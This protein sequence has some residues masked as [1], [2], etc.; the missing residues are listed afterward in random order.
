MESLSHMPK[1]RVTF[2]QQ[3][4]KV[5]KHLNVSSIVSLYKKLAPECRQVIAYCAFHLYG[6]LGKDCCKDNFI[7]EPIITSEGSCFQTSEKFKQT[8]T[9][10]GSSNS[11]DIYTFGKM[12]W[13]R[14]A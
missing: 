10:P 7:K 6:R 14:V 13:F 4:S 8:S 3:L 11:I 9:I 2:P 1:Y 12:I 5:M